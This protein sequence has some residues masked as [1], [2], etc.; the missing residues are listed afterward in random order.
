MPRQLAHLDCPFR[1]RADG[2]TLAAVLVT[3]PRRGRLLPRSSRPPRPRSCASARCGAA[4]YPRVP[5]RTLCGGASGGY[6]ARLGLGVAVFYLRITRAGS[7]RAS[8]S[9]ALSGCD[10]V[11]CPRE[12][13]RATGGPLLPFRPPVDYPTGTA[14]I[15]PPPLRPSPFPDLT[16]YGN[17]KSNPRTCA[18]CYGTLGR[19]H[20]FTPTP[21]APVGGI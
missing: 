4:Q 3:T 15:E 13:P 19:R 14:P 18:F 10:R 5:G 2:T 20:V 9:L 16:A 21:R 11:L 6:L 7:G 1:I 12:L 8:S 17:S